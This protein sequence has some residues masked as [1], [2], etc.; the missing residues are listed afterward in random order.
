MFGKIDVKV[1]ENGVPYEIFV[2]KDK[3]FNYIETNKKEMN[4]LNDE[5]KVI[6]A[7]YELW[8]KRKPFLS[9][10]VD[11]KQFY[12]SDEISLNDILWNDDSLTPSEFLNQ[13][14]IKLDCKNKIEE[15]LYEKLGEKCEYVEIDLSGNFYI[16]TTSS[17]LYFDI[18]SLNYIFGYFYGK[19]R[20]KK[21]KKFLIGE[22]QNAIHK[23]INIIKDLYKSKGIKL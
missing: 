17:L 23:N 18:K 15:I 10:L 5:E 16:S 3:V 1:F 4:C 13:E 14:T 11:G 12:I 2:D 19:F 8:I 9:F 6:K 22:V 7:I 20:S 21:N